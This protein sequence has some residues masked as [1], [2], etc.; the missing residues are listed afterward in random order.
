MLCLAG[1][2]TYTGPT[3]ISIGT[4]Q[5]G[6]LTGLAS[7]TPV[8][9]SSSGVL[10]LDSF[11]ATIGSLTG[12]GM[13]TNSA[14]SSTST[15]TL[16]PAAGATT[17]SG[18]ITDGAGQTA[19]TLSGA[20]TQVLTGS[21][22]YSG[23]TTISAGTL[24]IGSGGTIGSIT[25]TSGVADSGL[26]VF[27]LSS[28]TTTLSGNIT[29]S[30]GLKQMGASVLCLTGSNTYNGPTTI[31]AGTLQIGDGGAGGSIDGT[32]GVAITNNSNLL[33]FDLSSGTTSVLAVISGNGGLTQMGPS[34]LVLTGSNTYSGLTTIASGGT[35]QIG[36]GGTT[37]SIGGTSSVADNG[38]LAFDLS[39]SA[40]FSKS[41]TGLGGLTQMGSSILGVSG[42]NTY[43]GPTT[44][45][46]GTLQVGGA[47]CPAE[48]GGRVV[49]QQ[50]R[51]PGPLWQLA[52]ARHPDRQR[53]GDQ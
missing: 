44:I 51:G 42:N 39:N 12:S 50:R 2:N 25:G 38:L 31:I 4:L 33:A 3:T 48:L 45:S 21:N 29:G 34:L 37:G 22:T 6:S 40:T 41:V 7:S 8:S 14:G 26:L 27:D 17:F 43:S 28:G 11:S 32:S 23:L 30:G 5:I 47:Q 49:Q 15:L 52:D 53:H 18:V 24:Q 36:S 19:L 46:A 13:V 16:A 1:N 9:I 35:L 20:A 10:D